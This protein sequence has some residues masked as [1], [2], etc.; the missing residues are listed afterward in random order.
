MD[1]NNNWERTE[2]SYNAMVNGKG[3]QNEDPVKAIEE[4]YKKNVYD[5]EFVPTVIMDDGNP[6]AKI[7]DNDALI[8]YNYRPDRARQITRAFVMPEFKRFERRKK[9]ENLYFATFTEYEKGLPVQVVFPQEDLQNSLGEVISNAGLTQ[10]RIAETEKYAH[11]TYFFNGGGESKFEGEDHILVPSP[12][13]SNYDTKPEMSALEVTKKIEEAVEEDKYDFILVNYAN[14]DMVGHT[15]NMKAA[16]KG[17]EALDKCVER[18]VKIALSKNGIVAITA[19]HGTAEVMFNM[20]SGQIDKEHTS[21]PVP[22]ILIGKDYKG[23]NFGWQNTVGNDLS[24]VQPQGI[25]SDVAPTI[26]K[27]LNVEK[28]EEMTGMSLI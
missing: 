22:F 3:V 1:R 19:D 13:V 9:L 12:A 8:F 10:L 6:V 18:L 7:S 14:A 15:G 26:L 5:E 21:N 20:Q 27:L 25:L 16:I 17:I 28:P 23:K 2:K 11:V 24:L 4:S